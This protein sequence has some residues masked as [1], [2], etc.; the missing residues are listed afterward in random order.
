MN[1]LNSEFPQ[2]WVDRW[3]AWKLHS[4]KRCNI[5]GYF[6]SREVAGTSEEIISVLIWKNSAK[7]A[8]FGIFSVVTGVL[9]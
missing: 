8:F 6:G 9:F 3:G 1:K 2:T 4:L 7:L 5:W